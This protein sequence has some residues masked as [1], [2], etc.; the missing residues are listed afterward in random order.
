MQTKTESISDTKLRLNIDVPTE[1]I[2]TQVEARL[3][4][5][6]KT[7]K[8]DG[9]RPGK[10]PLSHIRAQY[11]AGVRQEVINDVIRDSVFEAIEQEKIRAV[12]A[13]NIEDVKLENDTLSYAA[14]VEIFPNVEVADLDKIEIEHSQA[15]VGDDD[16]DTMIENLR[17]Q[18]QTFNEKDG[19][20]TDGDQAIF[21]FKG[22]VDGEAFEGGAAED[23]KLVVGSGRMIPGFEDGL[24]GMKA[25]ETKTIEVTFPEDYQAEDLQGKEAQFELKV[26]KV[27]EPVLPEVDDAFLEIFGVTEGGV[28]KLKADVRKNMERE[29]KHAAR[30]R[31]KQLAF[32]GLLAQNEIELPQAMIDSEVERQR[33]MAMQRLMQQFGGQNAGSFDK[34]MF[35]AELFTEQATKSARLGVLVSSLIEKNSLEVDQERV[36]AYIAEMAENY[37][38]PQEVVDFYTKDKQQRGQIESVVLE[39]QVVDYI[40]DKAKVTDKEVG[41]QEL[42]ASAQQNTQMA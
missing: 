34:S 18:R 3:K 7:A 2:E 30:N 4:R 11:A 5:I 32:D 41:Y 10:V 37:E 35:P 6:A 33:D 40:V 17:K 20:I 29:V 24:I 9:F 12:G 36:E 39:D 28:D 27:E 23:F 1:R 16:V 19:E 21:D 38:D 31:L 22:S 13:P 42:L 8:I 14:T 25:G 15:K 26:S